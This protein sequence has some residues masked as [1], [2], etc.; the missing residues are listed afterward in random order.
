MRKWMPELTAMVGGPTAA[1]AAQSTV[2]QQ[3]ISLFEY[4]VAGTI[5]TYGE[6][7]TIAGVLVGL[8]GLVVAIIRLYWEHNR[9][10]R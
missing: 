1:G 3:S 9:R 8:G 10:K 7:F 6:L 4:P 2:A 5:V